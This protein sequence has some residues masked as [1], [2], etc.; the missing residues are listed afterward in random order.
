MRWKPGKLHVHPISA[1]LE[2]ISSARDLMVEKGKVLELA[3]VEGHE[4]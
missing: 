4:S 1:D 3:G 2:I